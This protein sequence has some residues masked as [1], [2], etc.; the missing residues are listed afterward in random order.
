[1]FK[2]SP[3]VTIFAILCIILTSCDEPVKEISG[4]VTITGNPWVGSTLT[5]DTSALGGSGKISYQWKR[6]GGYITGATGSTYTINAAEADFTITV[7]VSRAGSN[8]EITSAPTSQVSFFPLTGTVSITGTPQ[9]GHTLTADIIILGGSGEINYQWQRRIGTDEPQ[10]IGNNTN[11]YIITTNDIGSSISVCVTRPNNSGEVIGSL[12][13][14]IS[15]S[16][17]ITGTLQIGE[18]LTADITYLGGDG[19]A[20]YQWIR[21]S[22]PINN[23][24]EASYTIQ[25]ADEGSTLSVTATRSGNSATSAPTGTI[26]SVRITGSVTLTGD[27]WVGETLSVD[28]TNL[29]G[30]TEITYIWRRGN[31]SIDNTESTYTLQP[32]DRGQRGAFGGFGRTQNAAVP[33]FAGRWRHAVCY[34]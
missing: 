25:P 32:A 3:I 19:E 20:S 21:G 18:T 26:T 6:G 8:G 15:G 27:P 31:A 13:P 2:I 4:T 28:T 5:A 14:I 11:T 29:N 10:K 34:P 17:V 33:D 23:A 24:T 7:T 22:T 30:K 1:M 12:A 9:V 16:V